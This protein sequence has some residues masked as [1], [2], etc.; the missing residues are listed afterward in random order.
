LSHF[1]IEITYKVPTEKLD[2]F[3]ALHRSFLQ[4]GYDSGLLLCSGPQE[5]R[6]GGIVL[7]RAESKQV[8]IEFF[9]NDPYQK[10]EIA[11]YRFV[12]FNP[13]KFQGFLQDWVEGR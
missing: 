10:N 6:V 12:E 11:D 13:V 7:A 8:L 9:A 3:V 1:L 5:P 2:E 4:T